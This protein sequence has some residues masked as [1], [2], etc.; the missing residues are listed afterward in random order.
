MGKLRQGTQKRK[1]MKL[2]GKLEMRPEG[3]LH[4]ADTT[5]V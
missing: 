4:I 1:N 3:Q 2:I 5:R